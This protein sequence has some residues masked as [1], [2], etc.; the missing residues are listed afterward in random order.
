MRPSRKLS[1]SALAIAAL[2]MWAAAVSAEGRVATPD[3]VVETSV[4]TAVPTPVQSWIPVDCPPQGWIY[5][6][7]DSRHGKRR[8][9]VS[10]KHMHE[11]VIKTALETPVTARTVGAHRRGLEIEVDDDDEL[12]SGSPWAYVS[13]DAMGCDI[14][15]GQEVRVTKDGVLVPGSR[16]DAQLERATAPVIGNSA[17]VIATP[18]GPLVGSGATR[19]P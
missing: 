6:H 1:L 19:D 4:E 8:L 13:I 18:G 12:P 10:G 5:T 11:L 14:D 17:Y 9:K 2:A 3:D 7:R 16:Y 15:P